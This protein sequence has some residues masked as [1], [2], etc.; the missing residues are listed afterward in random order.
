[1]TGEDEKSN[2]SN[3]METRQAGKKKVVKSLVKNST[4]QNEGEVSHDYWLLPL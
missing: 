1:M 2:K 4:T 3:K